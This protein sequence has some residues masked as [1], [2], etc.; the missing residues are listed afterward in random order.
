MTT[1]DVACDSRQ[2]QIQILTKTFTRDLPES[3]KPL[4]GAHFSALV[5]LSDEAFSPITKITVKLVGSYIFM[6]QNPN[7]RS[8]VML[9]AVTAVVNFPT[10]E[11]S[12]FRKKKSI[13]KI[14]AIY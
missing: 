12:Q 2:I 7:S 3:F 13:L 9:G 10:I 14:D 11:L 5:L 8:D 6:Y 4:V 1:V